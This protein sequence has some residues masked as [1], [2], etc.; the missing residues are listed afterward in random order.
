MTKTI[1]LSELDLGLIHDDLTYYSQE[2]HYDGHP[3]V[4][5]VLDKIN[6]KV[7]AKIKD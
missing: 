4:A 3:E 1:E 5:E 2:M 7:V 6:E